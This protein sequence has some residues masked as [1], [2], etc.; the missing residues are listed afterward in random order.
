M[1]FSA[2]GYL[3]APGRET[4]YHLHTLDRFPG[5]LWL[6]TYPPFLYCFVNSF[7]KLFIA[8]GETV[9]GEVFKGQ[10]YI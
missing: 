7:V 8:V 6:P 9:F 2:L 5:F 10:F 4:E 3:S 1:F